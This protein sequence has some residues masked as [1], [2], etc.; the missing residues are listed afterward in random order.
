LVS[1]AERAVFLSGLLMK[2]MFELV[3][4]SRYRGMAVVSAA[5]GICVIAINCLLLLLAGAAPEGW[6]TREI[7]LSWEDL[8]NAEARS[9]GLAAACGRNGS[10]TKTPLL[11]YIGMSTAR[12]G[13]DPKLLVANQG[14]GGRAVGICGSGGGMRQLR[15]VSLPILRR[16]LH[17]S[18]VLLC[19]H[20]SWLGGHRMEEVPNSLNPFALAGGGNLGAA[21]E[22]LAWWNWL[23]K[24]RLYINHAVLFGLYSLRIKLDTFPSA[25]PWLPPERLNYPF[26]E[27]RE[28]LR[29]QMAGLERYGW[30][31]PHQY[32]LHEGQEAASV[33]ELI[34]ALRGLGSPVSVVYM[35]ETTA[36]RKRV[37][38]KAGSF[39]IDYLRQQFGEATLPVLNFQD[40]IPDE[41][42][43]DYCHLN[44]AGRSE[45]SARLGRAIRNDCH[46]QRQL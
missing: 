2:W 38:S 18:R 11:V 32:A 6:L 12:E 36:F 23:S 17:V 8:E 15:T 16:H 28:G 35:P 14:C 37:P 29:K 46:E 31:D 1:A 34:A 3:D 19:L 9:A 30:F 45:F 43:S 26:H 42:F 25:D 20:P 27:N 44:D 5:V 22:R 7:P 4:F 21:K 39:L 24:N 33:A 13:I 41:M 10:E 40:A